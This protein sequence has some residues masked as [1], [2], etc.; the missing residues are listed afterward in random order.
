[1]GVQK[2]KMKI[3]V[4]GLWHNG[5]VVSAC[6][7]S[8]K[9]NVIAYDHDEKIINKLKKNVPPIFEP[10]LKNLIESSTKDGNLSF[11]KNLQE[12]NNADIIWFTYDTPVQ[13]NDDADTEYVLDKIKKTLKKLNSNKCVIISSQLPVG[14]I[15]SLEI[16]ADDIL[17]KKF[18]FFCCPENLRLGNA[19]SSFLKAERI[20]VGYRDN[21]S[22]KKIANFLQSINKNLLWMKIESAEITKHAINSFL[23]LSISFINEISQICEHYGVNAKEV[24]EGLK[25]ETRIGRKAFL[26][27]GSP[28]SGGTLGRDVKFLN[29]I[30]KTKNLNTRIL[31]SI[32]SSNENHKHW[33]YHHLKDLILNK[34]IKKVA[35]W[36]LA[37]TENTDTLRRSFAIEI[38][39]W[40]KNYGIEV[41]GFDNNIKKFSPK[42]SK[43]IKQ[44]STPI[45]K[46]K[47]IDVLIILR[48]SKDFLNISPNTIEKLNKK[49]IIIDPNYFCNHFENI[50]KNKYLYVG[51]PKKIITSIYQDPEFKYN[52]KNQ[53]VIVTGA[54]K[55]LGY[56]VAKRF[57]NFGSNLVICSRNYFQ[58]KDAYV[59]LNKIKRKNQKILYSVTDVSSS[60]QVKK[61]I[62]MTIKKF[63]RIDVLVNNAGV[64]G[65]KGNIEKINW[66][67]WIKALEINLFGSIL[68]CKAVIPYFKK[69]N[70]GKIIQLSG[71]GAASPLPLISSYAVSK[72]AVVR[73]VENLSEELKKY[74]IDVNAVAPGPLNTDML[75]EVLK[76]GPKKVGKEFYNKSLMQKKTGGTPLKK[77]CDLIIFLGSKHSDGIRGK[78]ISALWDDWKNWT[79]YKKILNDTDLYTLRRITG[80]ERGFEWGDK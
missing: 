58:I 10:N 66:K 20:V 43:T 12:L 22:K 45:A 67:E 56:E 4:Q 37:Y 44:L 54:S 59:K 36:G 78:L 51:K 39:D 17:K 8:L 30:C 15:K 57:L 77:S 11:V 1:M 23:A 25:S 80:K 26:S 68:L 28:F 6:L 71:G 73:F 63:K 70:K 31:S 40:L 21:K 38:S 18:L 72:A 49:L 60:D 29:K 48:K 46:I 64:Y 35:I 52:F 62:N 53:V 16:Y 19:L 32:I 76:A 5:S 24:E 69:K 34:K 42:L 55:G 14:T 50:Y 75:K 33:I 61:L 13:S 74:N 41:S 79:R 3:F 2:K 47:R 7:A 65:P 27:P 9:H